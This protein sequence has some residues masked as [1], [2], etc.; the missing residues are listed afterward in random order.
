MKN[1]G[2]LIIVSLF[3]L[4][5]ASAVADRFAARHYELEAAPPS[6]FDMAL[7][8]RTTPP[9]ESESKSGSFIFGAAVL[10]L[11]V[12]VFVGALA[13]MNG[14]GEFLRQYRLSR[15]RGKRRERPSLTISGPEAHTLPQLPVAPQV[16][17]IPS[18][19][20]GYYQ[21]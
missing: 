5:V 6:A 1:L 11:G 3:L 2:S 21:E 15:K 19:E 18:L 9:A 14:G 4:A 12:L 7:E 13:A 8:S 17:R 16:R 10:G 20:E